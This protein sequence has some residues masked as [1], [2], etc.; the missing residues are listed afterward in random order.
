MSTKCLFDEVR[1]EP[2]DV[3]KSTPNALVP[4]WLSKEMGDVFLF[5]DNEDMFD[6]LSA[7][8][9]ECVTVGSILTKRFTR[10]FGRKF[11]VEYV[12]GQT[13]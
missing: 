8:V 4:N 9:C 1:L 10:V 3:L 13:L 11:S 6:S 2:K 7:D 12:S 5:S